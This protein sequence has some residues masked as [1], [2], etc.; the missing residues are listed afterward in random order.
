[1]PTPIGPSILEQLYEAWRET[2]WTVEELAEH[3][4]VVLGERLERTTVGKK[5]KG[6]IP[7]KDLEIQALATCLKVTIVWPSRRR[8]K[9]RRSIART[10]RAA[11]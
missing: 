3:L 10:T 9:A 8:P 2:G 6:Q 4:A 5:M 1:M 7:L 11:A